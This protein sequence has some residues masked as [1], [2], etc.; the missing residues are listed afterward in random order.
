[1]TITKGNPSTILKNNTKNVI[2]NTKI[3]RYK[4][5]IVEKNQIS[6]LFLNITN[7]FKKIFRKKYLLDTPHLYILYS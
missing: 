2:N 1:M 5:S 6:L 7:F 4:N 3:E